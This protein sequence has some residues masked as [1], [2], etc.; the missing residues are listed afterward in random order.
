METIISPADKDLISGIDGFIARYIQNRAFFATCQEAYEITEQQYAAVMG[1]RR[2]RDY[3]SFRVAQSKHN[4][5]R[6]NRR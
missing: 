6:K 3:D 2:Y 1:R 4:K 5:K